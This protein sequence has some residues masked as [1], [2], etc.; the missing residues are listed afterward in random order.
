MS[1]K[2]IYTKKYDYKTEIYQLKYDISNLLQLQPECLQILRWHVFL[3]DC[4]T[5]EYLEPKPGEEI[6]LVVV[7]TSSETPPILQE[8]IVPDI[9]TVHIEDGENLKEITVEIED[10]RIPKPYL[11][12]YRHIESE[13]EFHH[14][15]TQSGPK[16]PKVEP[17]NTYHRDTQ[18]I[19]TRNRLIEQAYSRATQMSNEQCYIPTVTDKILTS[20]KYETAQQRT[21]RLDIAGKVRTIQRYFRAWKMKKALKD[22]S[23]E[24]QRRL[25]NMTDE[26]RELD[27]ELKMQK[28]RE[29]NAK[30]F[31]RTRDD[32][33]MLYSMVDRWKKSQIN[34]ISRNCSGAAKLAEFYLL[35]NKEIEMLASIEKHRQQIKREM[36]DIELM[37]FFKDISDPVRWKGYK[38]IKVA[39]D[40]IET[41]KGQEYKHIFYD[42]C[43]HQTSIEERLQ[44]IKNL[45]D[46][47]KNHNCSL[48][49]E[50]V[51]LLTREEQLLQHSV[52]ENTLDMLRKRIEQLLL[53]HMQTPECN[54]GVTKRLMKLK[55]KE[56]ETNAN[57]CP[58]CNQIKSNKDFPPV[59]SRNLAIK[60]CMSCTWYDRVQEPWYEVAPYR[61]MLRQIRRD[62][63]KRNNITSISFIIQEKD[64]HYIVDRIWH[65][66]SIISEN[67]NINEL[68]LC[69][70]NK[71][72][73]W[74]P[75]NTML[76]TAEE[77]TS[78]LKVV[79]LEDVYDEDFRVAVMDKNLLGR[80]VFTNALFLKNAYK[81]D[82]EKTIDDLDLD[83]FEETTPII[84]ARSFEDCP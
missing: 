28:V 19:Q 4:K 50:L 20:K 70:W 73:E 39:M 24:Y 78:H 60:S 84:S 7:N 55:Q 47:L 72:E 59:N 67:S 40:T 56:Y 6:D 10:R 18:T 17:Y 16:F 3:N 62:E 32:F 30:T 37:K 1:H 51:N 15:T 74:S 36:K 44:F 13:I 9:I 2:K 38:G 11:G 34:R 21:R 23:A 71:E 12:G 46:S 65:S 5:V 41:Q 64:I 22:L 61:L 31:P 49:N 35:L 68:R 42:A 58:R 83:M 82:E 80:V 81:T 48:A 29:I 54:E 33:S 45:R 63:R 57:Y 53:K 77:I 79:N 76:I 8:N 27:E 43:N 52:Q 66:R 26:Q 75:W 25:K 14:A 69:R